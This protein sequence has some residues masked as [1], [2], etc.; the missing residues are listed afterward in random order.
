MRRD[1]NAL[2]RLFGE[3]LWPKSPEAAIQFD[4]FREILRP[5]DGL[6]MTGSHY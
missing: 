6:R 1:L 5:K 4:T 3:D 2:S